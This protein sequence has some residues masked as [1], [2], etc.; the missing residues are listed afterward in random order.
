MV[1]GELIYE[2]SVF[3]NFLDVSANWVAIGYCT[4]LLQHRGIQEG[5]G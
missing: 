3:S 4:E 2:S 1:V 5:R